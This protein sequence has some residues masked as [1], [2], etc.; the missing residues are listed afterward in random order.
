MDKICGRIKINGDDISLFLVVGVY[1][2]CI[3]QGVDH[4]REHLVELEHMVSESR[5]LG[6][7]AIPGDFIAHLGLLEGESQNLQGVFFKSCWIDVSYISGVPGIRS[8][9]HLL[10]W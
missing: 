5:L 8:Y 9:L 7:V 10:Q 1:L 2:P 6:P 4:Y 3:D